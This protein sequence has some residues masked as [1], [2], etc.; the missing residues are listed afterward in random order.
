[1]S[2]LGGVHCTTCHATRTGEPE[3]YGCRDGEHQWYT[4]L[5][6]GYPNDALGY[7]CTCVPE[8]ERDRITAKRK[9][10][11]RLA[12]YR[13]ARETVH[14][15]VRAALDAGASQA[16]VARASGLTRQGVAKIAAREI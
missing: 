15:D 5:G 2:D 16:D 4:Q 6:Q 9:A 1:M 8:P 7:P 13:D 3:I 12:Q 10:L 11:A 14:D